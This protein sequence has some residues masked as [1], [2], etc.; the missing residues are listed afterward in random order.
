MRRVGP[1]VAAL[2][3]VLI[4]PMSAQ[5]ARPR[6]IVLINAAVAYFISVDPTNACE[7]DRLILTVSDGWYI[8]PTDGRPIYQSYAG[9]QAWHVSGCTDPIYSAGMTGDTNPIEPGIEFGFDALSTAW[10]DATVTAYGDGGLQ[11]TYSFDLA[12]TANAPP[13]TIVNVHDGSKRMGRM[14]P[15]AVN[16]TIEVS[17]GL[18]FSP[19]DVDNADIG[20][21]RGLS[22]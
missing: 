16:G 22:E 12:W 8:R 6:E 13:Q 9:V 3:L 17:A 7:S 5:A 15:S 14:A 1:L 20:E 18:P 10:V 11:R 19:D 2:C 4:L 21:W